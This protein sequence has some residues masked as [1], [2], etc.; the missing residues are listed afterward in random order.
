MSAIWKQKKYDLNKVKN[1]HK[2]LDV[3]ETLAHLLYN[4]GIRDAKQGRE[5]LFANLRSEHSAGL[6]HLYTAEV[7]LKYNWYRQLLTFGHLIVL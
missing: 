5:F 6:L 2:E 1:L 7:C 4:R 3:S